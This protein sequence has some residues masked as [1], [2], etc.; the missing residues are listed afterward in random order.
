MRYTLHRGLSHVT[1]WVRLKFAAM[2]CDYYSIISTAQ[3]S[4]SQRIRHNEQ[5]IA[6]N[7][8]KV[9]RNKKEQTS[10]FFFRI[11]SWFFWKWK[12]ARSSPLLRLKRQN[13]IYG[14]H[15]K[16]FGIRVAKNHANAW[17]FDMWSVSSHI[18]GLSDGTW[19]HGLYPP[20]VARYPLRHTQS[21]CNFILL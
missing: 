10:E 5:E 9:F 4:D 20:K 1:N 3:A 13:V 2:Q 18:D 7:F 8:V 11:C 6:R 14:F 12:N 15:I 17:F 16:N 21:K 19:T